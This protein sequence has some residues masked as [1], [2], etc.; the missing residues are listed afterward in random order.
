MKI[1][2]IFT[3]VPNVIA[4]HP[5]GDSQ[6]VKVLAKTSDAITEAKVKELLNDSDFE[7]TKFKKL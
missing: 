4:V 2:E 7:L 3:K 5:F 1:R 6:L